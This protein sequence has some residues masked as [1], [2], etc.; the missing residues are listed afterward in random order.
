MNPAKAFLTQMRSLLFYH[1]PVFAPVTTDL[2][3]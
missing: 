2:I 3:L 1:A